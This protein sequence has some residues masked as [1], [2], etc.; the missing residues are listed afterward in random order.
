MKI[1]MF[2]VELMQILGE[3]KYI[4]CNISVWVNKRWWNLKRKVELWEEKPKNRAESEFQQGVRSD[5]TELQSNWNPSETQNQLTNKPFQNQLTWLEGRS[6]R[7][8]DWQMIDLSDVVT[9][10]AKCL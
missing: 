10:G 5:P 7:W 6:D 9:S 2:F 4:E 1:D 3:L 8:C